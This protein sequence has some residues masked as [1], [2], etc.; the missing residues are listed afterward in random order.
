MN[1]EET[2]VVRQA[3]SEGD[4]PQQNR[5]SLHGEGII[6][7]RK[8]MDFIPLPPPISTALMNEPVL[9]A[10]DEADHDDED[11]DDESPEMLEQ[12]GDQIKSN[13]NDDADGFIFQRIIPSTS[14]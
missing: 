5:S 4:Q 3:S 1:P 7:K 11:E 9:T 6:M 14:K 13:Y 8:M 10:G 12:E 2:H